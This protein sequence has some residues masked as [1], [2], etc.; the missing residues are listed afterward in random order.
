[1]KFVDSKALPKVYGG[2]SDVP[3][4][5][6]VPESLY[7]YCLAFENNY[8]GNSSI[9]PNFKSFKINVKIFF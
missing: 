6:I 8:L 9:S 5:D 4:M 1:M 3:I 7:N 2:S